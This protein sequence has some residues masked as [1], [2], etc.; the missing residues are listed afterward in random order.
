[1]GELRW[2]DD[3]SVLIMIM[4]SIWE[5]FDHDLNIDVWTRGYCLQFSDTLDA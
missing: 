2:A 4:S 3:L 1:M 5:T